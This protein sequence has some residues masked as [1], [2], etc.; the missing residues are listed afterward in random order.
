VIENALGTILSKN[1]TND[2]LLYYLLDGQ[3]QSEDNIETEYEKFKMLED[4]SKVKQLEES[5]FLNRAI[6]V[7]KIG[8]VPLFQN[9]FEI[10]GATIEY[11]SGDL[12]KSV[13]TEKHDQVVCN[14]ADEGVLSIR[15]T[16]PY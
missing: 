5:T 3:V 16:S 9:N 12:S 8:E 14:L 6:N 10:E 1:I 15:M 13:D 7:S 2:Y 4:K 11:G